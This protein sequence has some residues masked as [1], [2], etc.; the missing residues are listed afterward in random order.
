MSDDQPNS[1]Q[2]PANQQQPLSTGTQQKNWLD[3]LKQIFSN[4][5]KN[6]EDLL[7]QLRDAE[8]SELLDS[9]ALQIIEGAIQV[10]DM[11]VREVMIP[12]SQMVCI[13][14]EDTPEQFLPALIES[15][16]SRFPVIGDT[17][18]EVL[19]ILLAKDLLPLILSRRFSIKDLLRPATVVPESK[20]LNVLLHEFR[21]NRNHMAIVI[22]EYG[23]VAGLVTIEDVMEQIVGDIEDEYDVEEDSFIKPLNE[24]IY[25]V[26]ALTP[27]DDFNEHFNSNFSEEE[28]DTIG[29]IVMQQFGHLPKRNETITIE[30]FSFQVLSADNRRI[31]LLR[32]T[33]AQ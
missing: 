5:P 22:D 8:H 33:P 17:K 20:R 24:G 7:N 2:Q 16:H 14:L 13:Q 28:F 15:G 3:R 21:T 31:R 6:R 4:D 32:I 9:E 1:P 29:G 12:R 23:G 30:N 26:K 11:Q 27:I 19:G 25:V 18:D 10:V